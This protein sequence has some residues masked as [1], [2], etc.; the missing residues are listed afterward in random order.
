MEIREARKSDCRAIAE[1]AL[2]AGEGIPGHFWSEARAPGQDVL[3][4]GAQRAGAETANFSWRNVRIAL[5]DGEAAG[6]M[7]AYRL[8][9][10]IDNGDAEDVPAFI[11]PLIELEQCAPGSFYINML[12]CYPAYRNRSIGSALMGLADGLA[13]AAGCSVISLQVFEQNEAALRLYRRLGFVEA[14]RRAVVAHSCHARTGDV[15][16]LT[17]AVAADAAGG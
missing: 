11:R 12:A 4:V 2:I 6:M 7:L 5:V 15:L 13:A 10:T 1:L 8:P 3:D 14:A 16:L 9:D 17:R